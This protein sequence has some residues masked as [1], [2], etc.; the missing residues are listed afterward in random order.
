MTKL[1]IVDDDPSIREGLALGLEEFFEIGQANGGAD[2][3]RQLKTQ[4]PDL[5]LL[6]QSMKGISGTRLL[7][8]LGSLPHAPAVVIFSATMNLALARQALKL[9]ALDCISKP[10]SLS[11]LREKLESLAKG[12]NNAHEARKPFSARVAELVDAEAVVFS[13]KSLDER[14]RSFVRDLF[15]EALVD[16][17]GDLDRAAFRLGLDASSFNTAYQNFNESG[18][19]AGP[20]VSHVLGQ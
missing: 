19:S 4:T 16:A 9:G 3:L 14:R 12:R 18:A 20:S 6:D 15:H 5:M 7:E 13:E 2:A 8:C 11:S 1:M 10:F 17:D